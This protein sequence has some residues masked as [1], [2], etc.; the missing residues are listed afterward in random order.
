MS[1]IYPFYTSLPCFLKPLSFALS[2]SVCIIAYFVRFTVLCEIFLLFCFNWVFLFSRRSNPLGAGF[3]LRLRDRVPRQAGGGI[4]H[5]SI[6]RPG[7]PVPPEGPAPCHQVS[8]R[9]ILRSTDTV[10]KGLYYASYGHRFILRSRDLV[11]IGLY[12]APQTWWS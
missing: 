10:V 9:F 1:P 12:Y 5:R 7:G 6:H 4:P 11:V 8:F 2:T 3:R